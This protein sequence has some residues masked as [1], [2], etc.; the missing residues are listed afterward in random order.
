MHNNDEEETRRCLANKKTEVT[1]LQ[2]IWR[3][4]MAEHTAY[5]RLMVK[6]K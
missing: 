5:A 2:G 3:R 6:Y 4:G 1:V